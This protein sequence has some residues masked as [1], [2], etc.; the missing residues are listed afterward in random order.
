[1]PFLSTPDYIASLGDDEVWV[2]EDLLPYGGRLSLTAPAKAGKTFLALQIAASIADKSQTQFLDFTV[3][4]H[5]PVLILELD[6]P[7]RLYKATY[8]KGLSQSTPLHLE[9]VFHADKMMKDVPIPFSITGSGGEWL[10]K[11]CDRLKPLVVIIDTIRNTHLA[12]EN[13]PEVMMAIMEATTAAVSPAAIIWLAHPRKAKDDGMGGSSGDMID[14]TRGSSVFNASVDIVAALTKKR[15]KI[16]GR[17]Q[18]REDDFVPIFQNE[19]GFWEIEGDKM[20]KWRKVQ[21]VIDSMGSE[22]KKKDLYEKINE[23]L[24]YSTATAKRRIKELK[25]KGFPG[26]PD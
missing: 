9:E 5:G 8:A 12:D 24:H 16:K 13:K 7:P 20:D 1:M 21:E 15:F 26:E 17:T 11:E 18:R 10:R 6:T 14:Q 22:Y 4:A 3:R 19:F 2:I 23:L 25:E